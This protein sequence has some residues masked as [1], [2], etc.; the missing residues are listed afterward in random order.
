M[1]DTNEKRADAR[2]NRDRILDVAR[3]ALAANPQASLHS[4]AKAAGVGQGTLYRHFPTREAL[5]LGLYRKQ[6]EALVALA[7]ALLADHAPLEAFG[8][9][10]DRFA[11]YGRLKHGIAAIVRAAMTETDFQETYWPMVDA[12]RQLMEACERSDLIRPGTDPQD[13]LQLLALLMQ[14]PPTPE[15]EARTKRL[16]AL[17][18]RGLGA[19]NTPT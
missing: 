7:P 5:V 15:G 10:C 1:A 9:W 8:M 14:M 11:E 18:F 17:V 13:V 3:E 16:L 12:V 6:I 4:I 19:E 2:A